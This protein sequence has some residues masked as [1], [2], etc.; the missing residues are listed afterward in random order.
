MQTTAGTIEYPTREWHLLPVSTL[1][2]CL[3]RRGRIH[4]DKGS[5]SF[6]RFAG[7]LCK[8]TRPRGIGNAFGKAMIVNHALDVQVFNGNEAIGIDNLS[9]DL[10]R[11]IFPFEGD[12]LMHTGNGFAMLAPLRTPFCQFGMLA[13][14][15]CQCF[16]FFPEEAGIVYLCSIGKR[17]KG[18]ESDVYA[19]LSGIV[20]QSFC[21]TF[22]REGSVPFAGRGTAD[23]QGFD[24]AFDGTVQ[25]HLD[26]SNARGVELALFIDLET[27][28]W[29]REAIIAVTASEAGIPWLLSSFETTEEGLECKVNTYRHVLQHLRVDFVERG[30]FLLQPRQRLDLPIVAKRGSLLLIGCFPFLKQVIIEPAAFS[31]NVIQGFDLLFR[32]IEPVLKHLMHS[33]MVAQTEQEGKRETAPHPAPGR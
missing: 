22:H 23:G 31:E 5:T 33:V 15:F 30:A 19:Y 21:F 7:Q 1:A 12:P 9:T 10:M 26:M 3:T 18:V 14:H 11:E 4:S 17:G 32:R 27:R 2:A 24:R 20:R 29:I 13:L 16:L 28:L 6:F 8:E 25:H